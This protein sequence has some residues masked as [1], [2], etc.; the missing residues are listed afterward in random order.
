[1][2]N[3]KVHHHHRKA[4]AVV[5]AHLHDRG[6]ALLFRRKFQILQVFFTAAA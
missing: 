2:H 4:A 5:K 6:A 3:T 1:V